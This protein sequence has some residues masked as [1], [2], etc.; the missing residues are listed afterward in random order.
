MVISSGP[1]FDSGGSGRFNLGSGT[2]GT[3]WRVFVRG[4]PTPM[5]ARPAGLHLV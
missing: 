4:E 5:L 1:L 3:Q 2:A